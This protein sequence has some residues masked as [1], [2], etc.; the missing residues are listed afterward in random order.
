MSQRLVPPPPPA[1]EGPTAGSQ[2]ACRGL[3]PSS[4]E[5][6]K[7]PEVERG[8][9]R[10]AGVLASLPGSG[11]AAE[12]GLAHSKNGGPGVG[13]RQVHRSPAGRCPGASAPPL[14]AHPA[15]PALIPRWPVARS[16]SHTGLSQ[17]DFRG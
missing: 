16:C 2:G 8:P 15:L 10:R 3:K 14:V 13:S 5:V 9:R 11:T 1:Q 4:R 6:G 7:L 17:G 12:L